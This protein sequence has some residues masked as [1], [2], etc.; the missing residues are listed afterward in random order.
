MFSL[1]IKIAV[2]VMIACVLFA[3]FM[4]PHVQSPDTALRALRAALLLLLLLTTLVV[5]QVY[6]R[7]TPVNRC[8]LEPLAVSPGPRVVS[9]SEMTCVNRC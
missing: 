9:I 3:I 1:R 8:S 2:A 4:V 5:V 7:F 6:L